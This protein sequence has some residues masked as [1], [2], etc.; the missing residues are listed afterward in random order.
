MRKEFWLDL[1][2]VTKSAF[3]STFWVMSCFI[4]V[5]VGIGLAFGLC[6]LIIQIFLQFGGIR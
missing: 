3:W 1:T 5:G 4:L 6:C 2:E